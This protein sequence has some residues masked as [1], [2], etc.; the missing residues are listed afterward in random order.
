MDSLK[1]LVVDDEPGIRMGVSRIL[2]KHSVSYPFMDED[3]N[4][5]CLEAASGEEAIEIIDRDIPDIVLL[6][7]K[8]PGIKGMEVLEYIRMKNYDIMVAMITSYASLEIAVKATD[9]GAYDF[10][11]KPFTPQ[12]L[13]SSIDNITKQLFLKRIT[14]K[15]KQEGKQIRYQFLSVLSHELKAPL[16]AIEGYLRIMHEKQAGE[17]I[18]NYMQMIERAMDRIQGMRSL[19]MDLLDFTR[20]R[21]EKKE[22]KITT[23]NMRELA[24][25]SASTVKP[26]AIQKNVE[27]KINC[28]DD[29]FVEANPNDLEI[30]LNNLISNAVKYNKENGRVDVII[31]LEGKLLRLIIKDTGIGLTDEEKSQL[32]HAFVRIRNEKTRHITGSGLGLSIVRKITEIYNGKIEVESEPDKGSSFIVSLTV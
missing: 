8:L 10:I 12:E 29:L 13:K 2:S 26:Y 24:K 11:P 15:M 22:D 28:P 1:V 4:F 7:N 5:T 14:S 3:Y 31:T 23:V 30:I 32:F 17:D 19:I 27:I 6:D 20:I 25:I 21:L 16:N 9:D 18:A